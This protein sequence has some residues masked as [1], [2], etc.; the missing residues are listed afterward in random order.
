VLKGASEGWKVFR[1][2][3]GFDR[4]RHGPLQVQGVIYF[5]TTWAAYLAPRLSSRK[6]SSVDGE[7]FSSG[8]AREGCWG[9]KVGTRLFERG[10]RA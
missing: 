3:K 6:R 9:V 7:W 4:I 10:L 5:G 8:C 1:R 2:T